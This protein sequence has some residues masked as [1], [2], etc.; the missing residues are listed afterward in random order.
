[1]AHDNVAKPAIIATDLGLD[2]ETANQI[3][4]DARFERTPMGVRVAT[5]RR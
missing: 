3:L 2:I 4:Q 5:D 1:M